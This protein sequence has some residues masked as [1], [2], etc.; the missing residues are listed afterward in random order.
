MLKERLQSIENLM[1]DYN[2]DD[3]TREILDLAYDYNLEYYT[4]D[5]VNTDE[6]D[7]LV[8]TRLNDG[9]WQGVACMLSEVNYLNDEY[10][11]ING[12]GNLEELTIEYLQC[13]FDDLKS[14]LLELI[15]EEDKE[16]T[17]E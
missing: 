15:E 9:G 2:H 16:E 14:S 13:V 12:Y 11:L 8:Q 5:I 7:D 3:V 6:I 4:E 10:Y 17:E 1:K